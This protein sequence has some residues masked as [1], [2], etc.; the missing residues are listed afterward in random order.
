MPTASPP[1][2]ASSALSVWSNLR[3]D[4]DLL[5]E[6]DASRNARKRYAEYEWVPRHCQTSGGGTGTCLND[7]KTLEEKVNAMRAKF[8][9][10]IK[11]VMA[12][13][14]AQTKQT[15]QHHQHHQH[16]SHHHNQ[17][18]HGHLSSPV[19]PMVAV[20]AISPLASSPVPSTSL[21]SS[22]DSSSTLPSSPTPLS[23]LPPYGFNPPSIAAFPPPPPLPV[24]PTWSKDVST[25]L[26]QLQ[27]FLR[28][29]FE[30]NHLGCEF[31]PISKQR[32]FSRLMQQAREMIREGLPLKC[33]E[34]VVLTTFLTREWKEI[35]RIPLRFKTRAG[36][37]TYWH[38]VLAVA[39]TNNNG[40][41]RY[42]SVGLSRRCTLD[43]RPLV[44]S[45]LSA[46]VESFR[47]AYQEVEHRI[48]MITV[49]LPMA[50]KEHSNE[51]VAWHFLQLPVAQLEMMKT[52]STMP[53]ELAISATA[54]SATSTTA[55]V[56]STNVPTA[57]STSSSPVDRE[58]LVV[59]DILDRYSRL[60]PKI[61]D[62]VKKFGGTTSTS[63][64]V[65]SPTTMTAT[66]AATTGTSVGHLN[67]HNVTSPMFIPPTAFKNI[68]G[69]GPI[70]TLIAYDSSIGSLVYQPEWLTN[71]KRETNAMKQ[72]TQSVA[73]NGASAASH[74]SS[75]MRDDSDSRSDESDDSDDDYGHHHHPPQPHSARG[76]R[77]SVGHDDSS[78]VEKPPPTVAATLTKSAS[79]LRRQADRAER[80]RN[81]QLVAMLRDRHREWAHPTTSPTAITTTTANASS[82]PQV[83][84]MSSPFSSIFEAHHGHSHGHSSHPPP[85]ASLGHSHISP[86][87]TSITRNSTPNHGKRRTGATLSSSSS[88]PSR[89]AHQ[90]GLGQKSPSPVVNPMRTTT[91]ASKLSSKKGKAS[92]VSHISQPSS[93]SS[94]QVSENGCSTPTVTPLCDTFAASPST[95]SSPIPIALPDAALSACI[96]IDHLPGT[97]LSSPYT[98]PTI[99][100]V[101]NA[102]PIGFH[103][104]SSM[105]TDQ[106][107]LS[108]S[109]NSSFHVSSHFPPTSS[110][111]RAHSLDDDLMQYFDTQ[112]ESPIHMAQS[113]TEELTIQRHSSF[114][115][116]S[117]DSSPDSHP[118]F[119]L[120]SRLPSHSRSYSE[121]HFTSTLP[122][123]SRRSSAR[124]SQRLAQ[125]LTESPWE[126]ELR[127]E[128]EEVKR[129]R[130][131]INN[132]YTNQG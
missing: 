128:E 116:Q 55:G 127:E 15:Q 98:S 97:M 9:E 62:I 30:Y 25:R 21:S 102:Q 125:L 113:K 77:S 28:S 91:V 112:S 14:Q 49:G 12:T 123:S 38:I 68:A 44:F 121:S 59:C 74:P 33:L 37:H 89:P 26:R 39:M 114:A 83:S 99:A 40:T 29:S 82:S 42:G 60:L 11:K 71:K 46:L 69:H 118:D 27:T 119:H 115:F 2:S 107:E 106:S 103:L 95:R 5:V 79:A 20:D 104:N 86:T 36:G 45:S 18:A 101:S 94:M 81:K 19:S 87:T 43:Y 80:R 76:T 110:P 90:N 109:V 1:S 130:E 66:T 34:A 70:H 105:H 65:G 88:S 96:D 35:E 63:A 61:V 10:C 58:W 6:E 120:S 51:R 23:P 108:S 75:K 22:F 126:K 8:E 24:I 84:A 54:T 117:P 17:H 73:A 67:S 31:H 100:S 85:R 53:S 124:R 92:L 64:S 47:D 41:T 132:R 3:F 122:S 111:R 131:R 52:V 32:V 48:H 13:Y 4:G 16:H 57:G 50:R 72:V 78:R 56:T 93:T 129:E 7:R